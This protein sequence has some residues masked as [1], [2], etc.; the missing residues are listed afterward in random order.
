MFRALLEHEFHLVIQHDTSAKNGYALVPDKTGP[1]LAKPAEIDESACGGGLLGHDLPRTFGRV[2]S[3]GSSG[4]RAIQI[5]IK[6][7]SKYGPWESWLSDNIFR[8]EFFN[9]TLAQL[10]V[11]LTAKLSSPG[12]NGLYV[13]VV[14]NSGIQGT[15]DVVLDKVVADPASITFNADDAMSSFS[16]ALAK[17]GLK[18]EHTRTSAEKLVVVSGTQIPT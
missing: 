4:T 13:P 11:Y 14:D 9:I 5:T 10:A 6:S 12:S 1:K 3:K 15:W 16:S 18:L 2:W 7:D 8:T 17:V